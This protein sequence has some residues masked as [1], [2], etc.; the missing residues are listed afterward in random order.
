[1]C[2]ASAASG[3]S[4]QNGR[5][6]APSPP[7]QLFP[8]GSLRCRPLLAEDLLSLQSW[9]HAGA[10]SFYDLRPGDEERAALA[11]SSE[12][13]HFV[14]LDAAGATVG[15]FCVGPAARVAGGRYATQAVDVGLVLRPDL[16]GAGRGRAWTPAVL[17]F[18]AARYGRPLRVTVAAWNQPALRL[19]AGLGFRVTGGFG[20]FRHGPPHVIL[21]AD[22]VAVGA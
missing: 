5:V 19:A 17:A 8:D 15:Y 1:M 9:R 11:L 7:V 20:G 18:A 6:S 10:A 14:L 3:G 13:P 2:Q 12:S 22:G 21:I 4:G 16:A